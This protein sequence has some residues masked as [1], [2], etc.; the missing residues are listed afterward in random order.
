[1]MLLC[2][3]CQK[4]MTAP[5]PIHTHPVIRATTRVRCKRCDREFYVTVEEGPR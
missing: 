5:D 4:I 3:V 2:P 1:M